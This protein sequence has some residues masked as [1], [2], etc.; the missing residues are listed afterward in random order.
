MA[1]NDGQNDGP[2]AAPRPINWKRWHTLAV[3]LLTAF[4]VYM[5]IWQPW[6]KYTSWLVAMAGLTA[7][8]LITGRGV[9]GVWMGAFIDDRFRMSL[10]R[11]QMV[12]WTVIVVAAFGTI[13]IARLDRGALDALDVAVPQS[14]WILLGISTTSLIGSPLIKNV[15]KETPTDNAKAAEQ[16]A[17]QK[18]E[19]PGVAWEGQVVKNTTIQE[20]SVADFFRGEY[21]DNFML[22]D[23]GKIQMF[24]FTVLLA[25]AYASAIGS[26]LQNT[27]YPTALP[28]VGDGML[29]LL[30]ISHAGYLM[31][32]AVSSPAKS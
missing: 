1:D 29:P 3:L 2:N 31:S 26:L 16:V 12:I 30:G 5:A 14:L 11:L 9:T 27:P 8:A 13:A 22:L 25:L 17:T 15:K 4:F 23:V 21:L 20:A 24:F 6:G 10:S 7:F 18:K 19:G 28:D 32:K